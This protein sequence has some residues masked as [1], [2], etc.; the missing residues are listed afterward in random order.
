MFKTSA[1]IPLFWIKIKRLHQ[2]LEDV[3]NYSQACPHVQ[4]TYMKLKFILRPNTSSQKVLSSL[5]MGAS[6]CSVCVR[7][8]TNN[9]C[10][11]EHQWLCRKMVRSDACGTDLNKIVL[12][13]DIIVLC[14]RVYVCT[15]GRACAHKQV[16]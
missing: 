3:A 14:T 9:K 6:T 10:T 15:D 2:D 16:G 8:S 1:Q 12:C 11:C 5:G 13:R 7:V 4:E